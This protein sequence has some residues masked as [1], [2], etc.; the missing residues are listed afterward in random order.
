[1]LQVF[2]VDKD[3]NYGREQI[4]NLCRNLKL[5]VILDLGAGK[6]KDLD[7]LKMMYPNSRTLGLECYEDNC[8]ELIRKGH[9]VIRVNIEI[10]SLPL[11]DASV[12][13]IV[14]NQIFEH[15]KEVFW[16]FHEVSRVLKPNGILIVGVPN[17]ASL[18][19]RFLLLLGKQPTSIQLWSAH[20]R[21]FTDPGF[22]SFL[23]NT[24]PK[25]YEIEELKGSNFYP[26]P[27][28]IAK[29][30]AVLFPKLSVG[31]FYKLRRVGKYNQEFIDYPKRE[32]LETNFYLG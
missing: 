17:L 11:P 12:D 30:L 16:I 9:E 31:L 22:R 21:G 18:H 14:A 1:M 6:G 26:F 24:F 8:K 5:D 29:P 28:Y 7:N 20:I 3:L 10:S 15:C 32:K 23:I 25:G 19:N 27:A 4:K 13:L 2:Q